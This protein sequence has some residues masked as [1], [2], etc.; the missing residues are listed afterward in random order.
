L[1]EALEATRFTNKLFAH[2]SNPLSYEKYLH[3][4]VNCVFRW[5]DTQAYFA[6]MKHMIYRF[7]KS[8]GTSVW[9]LLTHVFRFHL[10]GWRM[11]SR[12]RE[13][14]EYLGRSSK[15]WIDY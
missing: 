10:W 7:K 8:L 12:E 9:D 2:I 14:G 4:Q 5:I 15:K 3:R 6:A 1:A 11:C 13:R